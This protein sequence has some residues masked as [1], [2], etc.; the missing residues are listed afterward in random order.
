MPT[1]IPTSTSPNTILFSDS[2]FN[3]E[4]H[5]TYKRLNWNQK[6]TYENF[7][8]DLTKVSYLKG[9]LEERKKWKLLVNLYSHL[10]SIAI[11]I[12]FINLTYDPDKD[13]IE[14]I[15]SASFCFVIGIRISRLVKMLSVLAEGRE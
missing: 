15:L 8:D 6:M 10:A 5:K 4:L 12:N 3:R 7:P 9:I 13:I 1:D 2:T 11:T 14:T